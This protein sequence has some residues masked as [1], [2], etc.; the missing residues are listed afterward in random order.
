M[1][2]CT[3]RDASAVGDSPTGK[4]ILADGSLREFDRPVLASSVLAGTSSDRWFVCDADEMEFDRSV[5]AVGADEWLR[6]GQIYFVLP[7]STLKSPL[8]AED[9]AKLA[10]KA[11][12]ALT[13]SSAPQCGRSSVA[14]LVFE[15]EEPAKPAVVP[16]VSGRRRKS[17]SGFGSGGRKLASDLSAIPE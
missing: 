7:K 2:L 14:P 16:I 17:R 12:A 4:L 6:P 3:S 1:G 15:A 10:V 13:R 5:S 9:L 8:Q 11:S